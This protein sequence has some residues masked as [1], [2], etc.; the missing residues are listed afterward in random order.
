MTKPR[1]ANR[2][3]GVVS[4]RTSTSACPRVPRLASAPPHH[5]PRDRA[6]AQRGHRRDHR[7]PAGGYGGEGRQ[8][9]A[10]GRSPQKG[11]DP[12]WT[13]RAH[14]AA[15]E[16]DGP[17]TDPAPVPMPEGPTAPAIAENGP[18]ERLR[19]YDGH[20]PSLHPDRRARWPLAQRGLRAGGVGVAG[21]LPRPWE[22]RAAQCRH[23]HRRVGWGGDTGPPARRGYSC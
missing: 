10:C 23:R 11:H 12:R 7:M 20:C 9:G 19:P 1:Q 18:C 21:G 17:G 6:S 13:R 22:R 8:C 14:G 2:A 4:T 16:G 3:T 15:P 5:R